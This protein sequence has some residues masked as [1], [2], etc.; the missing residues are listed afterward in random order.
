MIQSSGVVQV[1]GAQEVGQAEF[2][3]VVAAFEHVP[4]E[5]GDQGLRLKSGVRPV[6]LHA[7]VEE[8]LGVLVPVGAD[9][10]LGAHQDPR[11]RE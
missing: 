5:V 3:Y 6:D 7:A 8:R 9:G 2:R 1:E 4:E 10:Q 11:F